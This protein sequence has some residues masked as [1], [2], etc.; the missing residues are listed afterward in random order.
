VLD[1]RKGRSLLESLGCIQWAIASNSKIRR[2]HFNL[3]IALKAQVKLED[4]ISCYRKGLELNSNVAAAHNTLGTFLNEQGKPD[5]AVAS[6]L[7]A[8]ELAPNLP[9]ADENLRKTLTAQ[10]Q[11]DKLNSLYA[12]LNP[13]TAVAQFQLGKKLQ[14]MGLIEEAVQCHRRAIELD[15]TL[16]YVHFVLGNLL[17]ERGQLAEA[18]ASFR[19]AIEIE[20]TKASSHFCLGCVLYDQ[21]RLEDAE[22]CLRR[23]IELDDT[24]AASH[25]VLGNVLLKLGRDDEAAESYIRAVDRDP[26]NAHAHAKL[27]DIRNKGGR[28][29][30]AI[31][32]YRKAI[33]HDGKSA[34]TH[35]SLGLA[36]KNQ[37]NLGEAIVALRRA[38]ELFGTDSPQAERCSAAIRDCEDP[39]ALAARLPSIVNGNEQPRGI[40]ERLAFAELAYHRKQYAGAVRLWSEALKSDLSLDDDRRSQ[41]RY[42]AACA[43][44]WAGCENGSDEPSPDELT[45]SKLRQ[46]ALEWLRAE[47]TAW[48]TLLESPDDIQREKISKTLQHWQVDAELK[49]IRETT[50]L[51]KLPPEEQ[52]LFEQLW[53][54]VAS[55]RTRTDITS[56]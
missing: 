28:W 23:A 48:A 40:D 30:E 50:E 33:D 52:S 31:A 19:K 45:R 25:Y 2:A 39:L 56:R 18:S 3:G 8:L 43:A 20:P 24:L 35:L 38:A 51:A 5:E 55:L 29:D 46:Q 11:L 41:H 15:P 47:L 21:G 53:K 42:K 37:G 34:P 9:T 49:G 36:L 10:G 27:G 12:G 22:Q 54:D 1:G 13:S 7:T 6:F 17:R 4:A 16:P 32:A 44:V 26:T 14:K